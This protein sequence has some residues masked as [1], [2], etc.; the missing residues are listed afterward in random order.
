MLQKSLASQR[1][2]DPEKKKNLGLAHKIYQN[3]IVQI[4]KGGKRDF[5]DLVHIGL[6]YSNYR[7]S[8]CWYFKLL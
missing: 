7:G 6:L 2:K 5:N 4:K 8:W 1:A 3:Y